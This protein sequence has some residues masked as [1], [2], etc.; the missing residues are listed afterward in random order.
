MKHSE[1]TPVLTPARR[2]NRNEA[3]SIMIPA[4]VVILILFAF[5]GLSLD[6][7]YMHYYKRRMQTAADAAAVSGANEL[8]RAQ[9]TDS[10]YGRS[11]RPGSCGSSA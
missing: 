5:M 4:A 7:S 11:V 3:G 6:A 2:E 1:S 9:S 8:L 10:V